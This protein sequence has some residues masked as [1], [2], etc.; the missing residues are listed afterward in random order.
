MKSREERA[1]KE[2]IKQLVL[3]QVPLDS[4]IDE[5]RLLS[6]IDENIGKAGSAGY[7]RFGEKAASQGYLQFNAETGRTSGTS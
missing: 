1:Q 2:R 4:E 7:I 3:D 6:I 5:D